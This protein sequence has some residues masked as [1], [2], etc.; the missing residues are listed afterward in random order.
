LGAKVFVGYYD[1][2]HQVLHMEKTLFEELSD[3]YPTMTNTEIRN[4]LAA[5]LFTGDDVFK[6]IGD[7]S[8]GERGRVSLAKL[9]LSDCNFLILDEPTNHL[10]INSREILENA[11]SHYTGTVLFVSH[12][13]YFINQ[14]ATRILELT[15]QTFVNY[16]GNYDYYL[17]KKEEL[18]LKLTGQAATAS[19]GNASSRAAAAFGGTIS[20]LA[21]SSASMNSTNS[22]SVSENKAQWAQ[23]KEE[24]AR[25]RKR[26]NDLA[27]TEKEIEQLEEKKDALAE[28]MN[29]PEVA[30]NAGKLLELSRES[31][32]IQARLDE[33][34]MLWEEL[35]E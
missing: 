35:A 10:D 20:G 12:D 22:A 33:L 9:M 1:Q 31:D 21:G 19:G 6:R 25:E 8:G 28:Q 14:T 30:R 23:R 2:E 17:E 24:Q 34:Y 4:I 29:D 13:R 3:T 7:L 26:Q 5:F 15:N 27:K 11:L 18:T 32:K 16:L